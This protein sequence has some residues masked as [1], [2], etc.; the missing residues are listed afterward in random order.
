[1]GRLWFY[2]LMSRAGWLSYRGKIMVMAF[3]GVHVPLLGVISYYAFIAA[4]DWRDAVEVVAAAL[5]AT[6]IGTGV[7]LLVLNLLLQ[8]VLMTAA[9]LRR[10]RLER[11]LPGLP[12]G[13]RDEAGML[14]EDAE[15][16]LGELDLAIETMANHDPVT[17]LYNRRG[18]I[19]GIGD[20][21][22]ADQRFALCKLRIGNF[23]RLIATFD[24]GTAEAVLRGVARR[25]TAALPVDA[26]V[27]R[28]GGGTLGFVIDQ[29]GDVHA[30][31][32]RIV[33]THASLQADIAVG[34]LDIKPEL[35]FGVAIY[36]DDADD[37][38]A[39]LD[40]ALS[41][42]TT[43]DAAGN[44]PTMFF[45]PT[46]R[47]V[48]RERFSTEQDLRRALQDDEFTLHFQPVVDLVAG[49]TVGAEALVRWQ[50]PER[51]LVPPAAFIPV[52]EAC[53]LIE[54]IGLWVFN[55]ACRQLRH[56][57]DRGLDG[58]SLA[59]NLSGR[60]FADPALIDRLARAIAENGIAPGRI[61]IELTETAA[62]ADVG[63]TRDVFGELRRLG[64]AVAIDDFGTG[65]SSLSYLK[66]LPFD[67][68]K[69]DRQFVADVHRDPS[70][71]AICG[72]L[73]ELTRGLGISVLAE[74]AEHAAEVGQLQAQ[75]CR[76]F[77]GFHFSRPVT[78]ATFVDTVA[79]LDRRLAA[80]RL[81]IH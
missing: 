9:G 3:L 10:Y 74:G 58:L 68:L 46:A 72:A 42:L 65:Y 60:Q 51:G 6:L 53:G 81:M 39:L 35:T 27:S 59:V 41:A 36:P 69:I 77:Q 1:M 21:I 26:L 61:E 57:S 16:T 44:Q 76:L 70:N 5:A 38:T 32:R 54:P 67:R 45:S 13:Y 62:M 30:I 14:M 80:E 25:A 75:G 7:T 50:H 4:T 73:I 31:A 33:A 56:W 23:D 40:N 48:A 78:G 2:D 15:Q 49:R 37:A 55:A 19:K 52:A 66:D 63:R 17:G 47:E 64:I 34:A 43:V 28:L 79:Q 22:L 8:P 71:Q 20:R 11:R 29:P 24:L 18:L 12:V